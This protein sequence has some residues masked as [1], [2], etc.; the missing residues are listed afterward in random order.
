MRDALAPQ[1]KL[2]IMPSAA[3]VTMGEMRSSSIERLNPLSDRRSDSRS[4]FGMSPTTARPFILKTAARIVARIM[5]TSEPGTRAPHFFGQN[6]ITST[7]RRPIATAC[8]LGW[9]PR[10]P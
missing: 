3:I 2:S 4:V 7:T 1:S 6:T 9:K 10:R 8:M 5:P